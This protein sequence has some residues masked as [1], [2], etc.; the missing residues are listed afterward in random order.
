MRTNM[1]TALTSVVHPCL[2]PL[3]VLLLLLLLLLLLQ[4]ATLTETSGTDTQV[5]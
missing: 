4:A 3:D 2:L 1:V 5:P